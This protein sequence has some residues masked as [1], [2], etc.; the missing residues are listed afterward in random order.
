M[1]K[2]LIIKKFF[3]PRQP[4]KHRM[5]PFSSNKSLFLMLY[6][7]DSGMSEPYWGESASAGQELAEN[8][9]AALWVVAVRVQQRRGECRAADKS[10]DASMATQTGECLNQY[11]WLWGWCD[12]QIF[13]SSGRKQPPD[14]SMH[15]GGSGQV[16][17]KVSLKLWDDSEAGAGQGDWTL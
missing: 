10:R 2:M 17:G 3:P 1:N 6:F 16:F 5:K 15:N 14:V 12:L 9:V 4:S 8:V 7:L 11:W 13:N